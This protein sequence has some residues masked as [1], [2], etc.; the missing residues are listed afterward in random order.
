MLLKA[1]KEKTIKLAQEGFFIFLNFHE[2]LSYGIA[3]KIKEYKYGFKGV[4]IFHLC[5]FFWVN[6][7]LLWYF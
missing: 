3:F 6:L 5:F 7:G 4:F 2:H 1:K